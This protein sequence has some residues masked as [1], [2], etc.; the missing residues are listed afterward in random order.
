MPVSS[1]IVLAADRAYFTTRAMLAEVFDTFRLFHD[2]MDFLEENGDGWEVLLLLCEA[3]RETHGCSEAKSELLLGMLRLSSFELKTNLPDDLCAR[4]LFWVLRPIPKL[5]EASDLL[6]SLGGPGIIDRVGREVDAYTVLHE[7]LAYARPGD[8]VSVVVARGP[9]LHRQVFDTFYTPYV[10]SPSS[11]AMYSSRT[12]AGWVHALV[13]NE[14]NLENFI[15]QELEQNSELHP[16][17]ERDTLLALFTYDARPDLQV[18]GDLRCSDCIETIYSV[19]VE[20]HWRH[21]LDTL[22]EGLQPYHPVPA[23]SEVG[24]NGNAEPGSTGEIVRTSSSDRIH[25]P[26]TTQNHPLNKLDELHCQSR[27]EDDTSEYSAMTS[28]ASECD[29]GKHEFVCMD[30]WVHYEETGTRG[31]P[32]DLSENED[33][34]PSD[35]ASEDEYSP[36]LIH[37]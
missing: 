34:S 2:L 29:Y 22:K 30:C 12:F 8:E 21:F 13:D 23:G 32:E 9:D 17:W 10:E 35:E 36:F 18:R 1:P 24:D 33:F 27:S 16:G 14:V 3:V 4:M 11:L 7:R 37:S 5:H 6:L 31:P 25:E 28:I 20:P 15:N 26:Y 19:R